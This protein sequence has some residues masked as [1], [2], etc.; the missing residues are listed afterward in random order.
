MPNLVVPSTPPEAQEIFGSR[1]PS[2]ERYVEFLATA[3]IER[4]LIGPREGDRLWTRHV[5]NSTAVAAAI[6]FRESATAVR[7][8]DIGS[9]AGLPGIPLALARPDLEVVLVEPL[10]RRTMFLAEIIEELGLPIRV[11][12]G[13]AED[14]EVLDQAGEADVVTARAVAPLGKLGRWAAPLIT[15]GGRLVALKGSSAQ[16]EIDRDSAELARHGLIN[17]TVQFVEVP[18]AEST[19]LVLSDYR[20]TLRKSRTRR[21]R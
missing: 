12:R 14:P 6:P 10:L 4:G 8:T 21:K 5:L 18:G 9:G 19:H 1:L 3:G 16:E 13:R 7:V 15:D 2:A 11:V 17:P 20:A